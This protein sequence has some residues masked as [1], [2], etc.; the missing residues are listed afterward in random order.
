MLQNFDFA[1]AKIYVNGNKV[2]E[3]YILE[4]NDKC[5]IRILPSGGGFWGGVS[6]TFKKVAG[7]AY[8]YLGIGLL[9][10]YVLNNAISWSSNKIGSLFEPESVNPVEEYLKEQQNK[11]NNDSE[12][13]QDIPTIQ[14][15]KNRVATNNPIPLVIGKSLYTPL[16]I[17][18]GYTTIDPNDGTLGENQYYKCLYLLGYNDIEIRDIKLGIY[19]LA[20]NAD[21][22]TN[23]RITMD[24][25]GGFNYVTSTYTKNLRFMRDWNNDNRHQT[26]VVIADGRVYKEDLSVTVSY[27]HAWV[28]S[29]TV[30]ELAGKITIDIGCDLHLGWLD[31]WRD[32][33]V[34]VNY[35]G[36]RMRGFPVGVHY[37]YAK[38]FPALE[39]QQGENEVSLYDQKVSQE[40]FST[41][42]T[43]PQGAE[44]LKL[45]P[46]S[47]TYPSKVELEIRLNSL[48]A[49]DSKGN[50]QTASVKIAVAYSTNGGVSYNPFDGFI[51]LV[52]STVN[53]RFAHE[54]V[55][56]DPTNLSKGTCMVTTIT[57]C[58]NKVMRFVASHSFGFNDAF[59]ND[60]TGNMINNAVEFIVFRYDEEPTDSNI[61]NAVALSA[62]RTWH[63]DYKKSLEHYQ[64]TGE[65]ILYPQRPMVEKYRNQTARLGF[66]IKADEGC[67]GTLNELNCVV[68]SKAKICTVGL[69]EEGKTYTWSNS[70]EYTNN[71]ASLALMILEH[72]SR[73]EYR[74]TSDMIDYDSFGA[75]YEYC[76]ERD[77]RLD[78]DEA[79]KYVANGV[80]SKQFKTYDLVSK[81]L[82][83][84]HGRLVLNNSKYAV[85]IDKAQTTPVMM[86][87]EQNL[88]DFSANKNFDEDIDGYQVTFI[89][90]RNY[91][92]QDT[93]ICVDEYAKT[94]KQPS[95][96]KLESLDCPWTTDS[97]RVYRWAMRKLAERRLRPETWTAKICEEG[98]LCDYGDMVSLQTGVITV[99]IGSGAEITNYIT[100][101]DYITG[102]KV[103]TNF[104]IDDTSLEY[105][106]KIMQA[107][108]VRPIKVVTRKLVVSSTEFNELIFD[109]AIAANSTDKP[110]IGDIVSFGLYEKIT[111]NALVFGKKDNGDGTYQLTLVPYQ[112]GIYTAEDGTI[113]EFVSNVT[114]PSQT[115]VTTDE[116]LPTLSADDVFNVS[117]SVAK[118][119]VALEENDDV[120]NPN[121]VTNLSAVLGKDSISVKWD[122]PT[123][124]SVANSIKEYVIELSTD[125]ET[126]WNQI[127]SVGTNEFE[128][129]L[130]R[131]AYGYP[132]V[133][134][135]DDWVI[136]VKARNIY[137]KASTYLSANLTTTGYK[138]WKASKPT[139]VKAV[140]SKDSIVLTWDK[141]VS[142]DYGTKVYS[143]YKNNVL[144]ADN[145][146]GTTYVYT[147]NRV[148]DGF[149]EASSFANQNWNFTIHAKNE[150][151]ST[152]PN[153]ETSSDAAV[154]DTSSYGTWL[155]TSAPKVNAKVSDRTIMI[156][157]NL[158]ERSDQKEI[159]GNIRYKVRIRR[160]ELA[161][162]VGSTT[163][164]VNA[165]SEWHCPATYADYLASSDNYK[166][167]TKDNLS[168]KNRYVEMSGTYV[169]TMPL[170]GQETQNIHNTP[171][172]FDIKAFNEAGESDWYS[173][174]D[175]Y[176]NAT[177]TYANGFLATALATSIAD[178]VHANEHV[179]ESFVEKLSAISA[180][181]GVIQ[182]GGFGSFASQTNYWALSTLS[183]QDA[184]TSEKVYEGSF[185][186]GGQNEYLKV[187]P[188]VNSSG[189][190]IDYTISM[191][192]GNI[193][194]SNSLSD[195]NS[196]NGTFL[197]NDERTIRLRL[198]YQ[199]MTFQ[200]YD[201]VNQE[202][203]DSA[204]ISVDKNGNLII[205]NSDEKP[206]FIV[207]FPS[208]NSVVYHL[209]S[210]ATYQHD[211][212]GTNSESLL[213]QGSVNQVDALVGSAC[214]HG[215]I[216]KALSGLTNRDMLFCTKSTGIQISGTVLYSNGEK[217][218]Y[219][220][221]LNSS[222]ST[223]WGLTSEQV[224]INIFKWSE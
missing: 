116:S 138:T 11:I 68:R 1:N 201:S 51:A 24:G 213:F 14:G 64:E 129:T 47:K 174:S 156:T 195:A 117:S 190:I 118:A 133:S 76:E 25:D 119:A 219:V 183:P 215:T 153:N 107:D 12:K 208:A 10:K 46:F 212:N 173:G 72:P 159:Y 78:T 145:I 67:E 73:G 181:I 216:K 151:V 134:Y 143:V 193:E 205:S 158:P 161:Y 176:A 175:V 203:V 62:V 124:T 185:R 149:P 37:P 164:T 163:Q 112:E 196:S 152:V 75:F 155:F 32:V 105:G 54:I 197:Y 157:A 53:L 35:K 55:A 41:T 147:I 154:Y 88:L 128:Y 93:L 90:E 79:R 198:T 27:E 109:E 92:Q 125:D 36:L 69:N 182:K 170:Y 207:E 200:N 5:Y 122:V 127:G 108:G 210:N 184:G 220:E 21:N 221:P 15:S 34:T 56:L 187:E 77:I 44:P 160:G 120:G 192:A 49:H 106:I 89:D 18:N 86:I 95:E 52:P 191:K 50:R 114:P 202:W 100:E 222:K 131:S 194:F 13:T 179:K 96:Y 66:T 19:S 40:N 97:K 57:G 29:V 91:Y 111:D 223:D 167:S 217:E 94:H 146:T 65:K 121:P 126:T 214:F 61:Q 59:N 142:D 218:N 140:A 45:Y 103:D 43:Y 20:T 188:V 130:N 132:E 115:G 139:N 26:F 17:G 206:D 123:G 2:D 180:N 209:D 30:E 23:G 141:G 74:Y 8:N 84:G 101:G 104:M 28:E 82:M 199:G 60:G 9:D 7:F 171:Y 168:E 113:P 150:S 136:R 135:F 98:G 63:Y 211:Q 22:V 38:Y 3:N 58:V 178:V 177:G 16:V 144:V 39:I 80:I 162:N 189:Q 102:V 186:V 71:P 148:S 33:V 70:T 31:W 204:S 85:W 87:N 99:G 42:L 81:I 48:L 169:Q 172:Y 224:S 110:N 4:E 165:D 166:D 83:T 6:W 137:N